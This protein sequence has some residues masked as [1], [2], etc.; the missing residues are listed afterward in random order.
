MRFSF[1]RGVPST[2]AQLVGGGLG[3]TAQTFSLLWWVGW[4]LFA[5]G[6]GLLLRG[7]RWDGQPWWQTIPKLRSPFVRR[8]SLYT[9]LM[10]VSDSELDQKHYLDLSIRAF[11]GSP[12]SFQT[13]TI[14]GMVGVDFSLQG[15]GQGGFEVPAPL[16][17]FETEKPHKPDA[18]FVLATRLFLQPAQVTEYRDRQAQ[19]QTAQIMF[20]GLKVELET[21]RGKKVVLPLWDGVSLGGSRIALVT[22]RVHEVALTA[23]ASTK[24]TIGT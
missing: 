10:N 9:G 17:Y 21:K 15:S 1:E 5:F 12:Y 2:A 4:S 24:A 6:F 13:T 23:S 18:E 22:G 7:A 19:G 16:L 8:G 11:N 3:V 20:R 14:E